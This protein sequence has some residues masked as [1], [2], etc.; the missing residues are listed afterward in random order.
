MA[1]VTVGVGPGVALGMANVTVGISTGGGMALDVYFR[2]DVAQ[3][4]TSVAVAMLSASAAH[5]AGNREYVR[6][7]VDTVRAQAISFGIEWPAVEGE[8]IA[9]LKGSDV[10]DSVVK[11]LEVEG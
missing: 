8:L 1:N 2:Q 7:V 10:I 4:I 9:A 3:G 5:G 11:V 6:G